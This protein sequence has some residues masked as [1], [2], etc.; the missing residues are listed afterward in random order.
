MA[1]IT[2]LPSGLKFEIEP[3]TNLLQAAICHELAWPHTCGGKAQC[4][5][6]AYVLIQGHENVTPMNRLEEHQLVTRKGRHAI[7]QRIRL[8]CQT[9][10]KGD[11]IVRKNLMEF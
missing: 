1:V 2:I 8:A 4:T 10:V 5:T 7:T 11:I 6:C 9:V 3:G